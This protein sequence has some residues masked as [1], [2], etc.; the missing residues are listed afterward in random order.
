MKIFLTG[1]PGSG[2]STIGKDLAESLKIEFVDLDEE[3]EK[4]A[5]KGITD[6]FKNEGEEHFRK[7]EAEVLMDLCKR[8]ESFVM[9][10]GGGA[11]CFHD[12][13]NRMNSQGLTIYLKVSLQ[14]LVKRLET[15]KEFRPLLA[16]ADS[17][18]KAIQELLL[19]RED[20]YKNAHFV[21]DS[22]NL[23]LDQILSKIRS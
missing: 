12:S 13:M 10:T 1:M 17:L 23:T 21:L 4:Y 16:N 8:K 18:K 14:E 20:C 15:E 6:I 7:I 5:E 9:S 11:P 2:K 3:I 22:D 19:K